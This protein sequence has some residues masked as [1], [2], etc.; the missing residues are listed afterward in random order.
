MSTNTA[1]IDHVVIN[2]RSEMDT[3]VEVFRN[4]GFTMTPRG[5]HTLGSINHLAMFNDNYLELL[6]VPSDQSSSRSDLQE[7]ISGIN[8]LVLKTNNADETFEH[9]KAIGVEAEPPKAFSR[10]VDIDGTTQHAKF[11]TVTAR[12]DAF[13]AGRVYYCEHATP[14]LVWRPEWLQHENTMSY[15][16]EMVVV[17]TDPEPAFEAYHDLLGGTAGQESDNSRYLDLGNCRVSVLSDE[18]Y[19]NRTGTLGSELG[20]RDSMFGAL[21]FMC[22]NL[23]KLTNFL[24]TSTSGIEIRENAEQIS[25]RLP[26]FATLLEIR[27]T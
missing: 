17:D 16:Y 12:S 22:E 3:A 23:S 13:P 25:R 19:R 4:L 10:P 21:V 27:S 20:D 18:Q 24:R 8:G 7:S 15:V 11:R 1:I 26:Q 9:F 14:D 6:G 2:V 5:F